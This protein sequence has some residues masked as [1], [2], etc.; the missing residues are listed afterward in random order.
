MAPQKQQEVRKRKK[1]EK[2]KQQR[3]QTSSSDEEEDNEGSGWLPSAERAEKAYTH[4]SMTLDKILVYT[5]VLFCCS[6]GVEIL[7]PN[8]MVSRLVLSPPAAHGPC[9]GMVRGSATSGGSVHV[10]TVCGMENPVSVAPLTLLD[11]VLVVQ[12]TFVEEEEEKKDRGRRKG[13]FV[14]VDDDLEIEE[15]EEE[16]KKKHDAFRFLSLGG[17][18]FGISARRLISVSGGRGAASSLLSGALPEDCDGGAVLDLDALVVSKIS[19][20]HYT[21]KK[22]SS[23]GS[24][25]SSP[26]AFD[27][28]AMV[29]VGRQRHAVEVFYSLE[30]SGSDDESQKLKWMGC[31]PLSSDGETSSPVVVKDISVG[32]EESGGVI[33]IVTH[34]GYMDQWYTLFG[35]LP[36]L[37]A[38]FGGT[39]V[40]PSSVPTGKLLLW[41]PGK[42]RFELVRSEASESAASSR[43]LF[44]SAVVV[45][46]S[47]MMYGDLGRG[48]RVCQ[49]RLLLDGS[50]GTTGRM[51]GC[52]ELGRS[53]WIP[54]DIV[55]GAKYKS[56]VMT[57]TK[58]DR[59]NYFTMLRCYLGRNPCDT[60][61]AMFIVKGMQSGSDNSGS[62]SPSAMGLK[63]IS[64]IDSE[65]YNVGSISDV[66]LC[67]DWLFFG[68]NFGDRI[69]AKY[70]NGVVRDKLYE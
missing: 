58:A 57:A 53:G 52:K 39:S 9:S 55:Y 18:S 42:A 14:V 60:H 41:K 24:S 1:E 17:Y 65:Y 62:S 59:G 21:K 54:T 69:G 12:D 49:V 36:H 67:K 43:L 61:W 30:G 37:A 20:A 28:V 63:T 35:L 27:L 46:G 66:C 51:I 48:G 40:F 2:R 34:P 70:I 16:E 47:E 31:I 6:L 26:S 25:S 44:P 23:G 22:T 45:H 8:T 32:D 29:N 56:Y 7:M 68:S 50:A 4:T 11:G 19:A 64:V 38:R 5:L 15:E 3:Q 13:G 33:A 10:G